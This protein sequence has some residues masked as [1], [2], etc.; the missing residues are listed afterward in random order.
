[1]DRTARE[2]ANMSSPYSETIWM[3]TSEAERRSLRTILEA[4][5]ICSRVGQYLDNDVYFL[6]VTPEDRSRAVE[7]MH[8]AAMAGRL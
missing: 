4:A 6:A 5:D 8:R 3:G 2:V 1:M 7:I